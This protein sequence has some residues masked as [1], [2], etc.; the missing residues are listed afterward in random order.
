MWYLY[1]RVWE[2]RGLFLL[3]KEKKKKSR[4]HLLRHSHAQKQGGQ[5]PRTTP[6]HSSACSSSSSTTGAPLLVRIESELINHFLFFLP[7]YV[8]KNLLSL[9]L[10]CVCTFFCLFFFYY[11]VVSPFFFILC[12]V[13][14]LGCSKSNSNPPM[15]WREASNC[16]TNHVFCLP[17][18]LSLSIVSLSRSFI[19]FLYTFEISKWLCR[20]LVCIRYFDTCKKEA[21]ER[22]RRE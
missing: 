5:T 13:L 18:L 3:T 8:Y 10:S 9:S 21:S 1:V 7:V 17:R 14:W 12:L 22:E 11:V 16:F 15:R 4:F 2:L 6:S 20:Q 19:L